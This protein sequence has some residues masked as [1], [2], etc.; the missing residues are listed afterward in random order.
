MD[1]VSRKSYGNAC[2]IYIS[3]K[4]AVNLS[5]NSMIREFLLSDIESLWIPAQYG[6]L[7]LGSERI[8][9]LIAKGD[10]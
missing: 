7:D 6:V 9:C 1:K 5:K 8:S 4:N 10:L 3:V 2:L